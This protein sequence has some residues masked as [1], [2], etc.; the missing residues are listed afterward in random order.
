MCA[1]A[2]FERLGGR[3]GS[4]VYKVEMNSPKMEYSEMEK[5][6]Q[7]VRAPPVRA[8]CGRYCKVVSSMA[9][10]AHQYAGRR[11]RLTTPM[12]PATEPTHHRK[13]DPHR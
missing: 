11:H 10:A 8:I 7:V 12:H 4:G 3:G 6:Q 9:S 13:D 1:T 2:A 5:L